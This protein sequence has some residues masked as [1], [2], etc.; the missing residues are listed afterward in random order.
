M[1]PKIRPGLLLSAQTTEAWSPLAPLSMSLTSVI[2]APASK[3]VMLGASSFFAI[4]AFSSGEV[5]AQ[6]SEFDIQAQPVKQVLLEFS[7][8]AYTL[9]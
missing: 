6:F 5:W 1:S 7:Q 8:A 2:L 9:Y 4:A 3:A